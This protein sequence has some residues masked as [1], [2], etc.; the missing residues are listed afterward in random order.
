MS[1]GHGNTVK[2]MLRRLEA[3]YVMG[4]PMPVDAIRAQIVEGIDIMVHVARLKDGSRKVLEISE[5]VG[6]E[7]GEY[8]LNKLYFPDERM[9]IT[10]MNDS[11]KND[12]KLRLKGLKYE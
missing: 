10:K 12:V 1:T 3:M 7:D 11:L 5:V 9:I 8:V 2:G 4:S 6:Y